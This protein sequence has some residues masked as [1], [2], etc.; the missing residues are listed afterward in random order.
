MLIIKQYENLFVTSKALTHFI[1]RNRKESSVLECLLYSNTVS[2]LTGI[3]PPKIMVLLDSVIGL[4]D[5]GS[6]ILQR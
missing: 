3:N 6:N 2:A 1:F 5:E 4:T